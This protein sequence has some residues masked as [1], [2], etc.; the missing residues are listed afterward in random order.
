MFQNLGGGKRKK[1]QA[2]DRERAQ[3][4][5]EEEAARL[6]ND[7]DIRARALDNV[8]QNGIVFLDE[9]D[10]IARADSH[11]RRRLAPGRAA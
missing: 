10:K 4:V 6:I 1:P 7:E 3:A 2:A 11:G 5:A 8:E 9:I